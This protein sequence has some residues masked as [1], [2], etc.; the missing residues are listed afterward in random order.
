MN[1]KLA[2]LSLFFSINT[3]NLLA[4]NVNVN[5]KEL[6]NEIGNPELNVRVR[7]VYGPAA[8]VLSKEAPL[9]KHTPYSV[10]IDNELATV[11]KG[12]IYFGLDVQKNPKIPMTNNSS[13]YYTINLVEIN[14]F[15]KPNEKQH[16]KYL[17]SLT[18]ESAGSKNGFKAEDVMYN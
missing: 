3:T 10:D 9:D 12:V 4:N 15:E 6:E 1:K 18:I 13:T 7:A 11:N 16:D 5:L 14:N 17:T 8:V 2:L